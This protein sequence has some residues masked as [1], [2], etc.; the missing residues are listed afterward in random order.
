MTSK[1]VDTHCW[2]E[3]RLVYEKLIVVYVEKI[4]CGVF[5]VPTSGSVWEKL[6]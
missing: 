1:V 2:T 4:V 6:S 5:I 3:Y